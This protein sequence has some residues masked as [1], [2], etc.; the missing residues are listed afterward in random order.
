[1]L[2]AMLLKVL[3]VMT[4]FGNGGEIFLQYGGQ[5][6]VKASNYWDTL[7]FSPN[8]VEVAVIKKSL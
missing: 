6:S 1:M 2:T 7:N 8:G 4:T 5:H 3:F